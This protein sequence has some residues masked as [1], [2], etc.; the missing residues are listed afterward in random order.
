LVSGAG[1]GTRK[2]KAG[3]ETFRERPDMLE[4][5]MMV[6]DATIVPYGGGLGNNN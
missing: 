2:F 6:F 3:G 4:P 5:A 1:V